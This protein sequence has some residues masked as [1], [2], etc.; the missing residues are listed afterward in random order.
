MAVKKIRLEDN[1]GYVELEDGTGNVLLEDSTAAPVEAETG[2]FLIFPLAAPMFR[3]KKLEELKRDD[4]E[5]EMM[6]V[7]YLRT[8]RN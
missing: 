4:A 5:D 6:V 8:R 1:S 3:A 7:Y 2:N